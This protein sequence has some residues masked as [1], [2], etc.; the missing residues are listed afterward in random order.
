MA[1]QYLLVM[2]FGVDRL[3]MADHSA[4]I[5]ET[6]AQ[7]MLDIINCIMR[8]LDSFFW[9][10]TAVIVNEETMFIPPHADIVRIGELRLPAREFP[11]RGNDR[12]TF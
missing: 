5:G 9:T 3:G 1:H 4:D 2:G 11:D 7:A 6:L 12:C 8:R 10:K